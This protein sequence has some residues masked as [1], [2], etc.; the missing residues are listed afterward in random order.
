MIIEFIKNI[1]FHFKKNKYT[2]SPVFIIGCGRSGTTILGRTLSNHPKIKYLNERRDL[3]HKIYPEFNIW[4]ENVMNSKLYANEK[5]YCK[6]K[7]SKLRNLF[8]KEQVLG[9]ATILLEKLPINN[10]RLK[11]LQKCFPKAK[12]IY[13]T[14]NGLEVSRSIEKRIQKNN[15]Y[16]GNKFRLLQQHFK[17]KINILSDQQKG[18]WEWKLS[19]DQS[20]VFFQK[21]NREKFIH[22]S[23]QDFIENT[24]DFLRKIFEFIELEINDE[25]LEIISQNIKRK[26]NAVT[27]TTDKK[28]LEIGGEI[29][30]Q[31]INNSYPTF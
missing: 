27:N 19:M 10:F 16:T 17:D 2:F 13:L 31:T 5:D 6:E 7:S 23:Y 3:W 1:L 29:L 11:F 24:E 9:N 12:Y 20:D 14:R 22:L 4:E 18:M 26:N 21:L 30:K 8:F 25:F 15:W 28:I